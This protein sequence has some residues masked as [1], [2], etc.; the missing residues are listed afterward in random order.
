M[1]RGSRLR[2]FPRGPESNTGQGGLLKRPSSRSTWAPYYAKLVDP[3][4]M[5]VLGGNLSSRSFAIR[6]PKLRAQ[7]HRPCLGVVASCRRHALSQAD[8][9]LHSL[10]NYEILEVSPASASEAS[11]RS[12]QR[13]MGQTCQHTCRVLEFSC[14]LRAWI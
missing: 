10:D 5:D 2:F 1:P 7:P 6:L 14:L 8:Y 9:S 12:C 3:V 11:K 13:S 4:C